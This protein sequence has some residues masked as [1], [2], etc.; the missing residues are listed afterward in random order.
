MKMFELIFIQNRSMFSL[1]LN[2]YFIRFQTP[3]TGA[4]AK[5]ICHVTFLYYIT[6]RRVCQGVFRFFL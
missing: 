1:L 4:V 3:S 5:V 6:C 2:Y